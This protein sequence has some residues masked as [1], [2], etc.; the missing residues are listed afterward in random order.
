MGSKLAVVAIGGNSL[1]ADPNQPDIAQQ[2]IAVRQ[3]CNQVALMVAEGWR[4]VLTHGNG[5]QVGYALLRSELAEAQGGYPVPLDIVVAETQGSIGYMLQQAMTNALRRLGHK[6]TVVTVITEVI[7]ARDDPAFNTPSKPIGRFMSEAQASQREASGWQ[8]MED[9]G[10]GWRRVVASPEPLEIVEL[11]AIRTLVDQGYVV[12][13]AGG[14]GVPVYRTEKGSLR[15][16]AAVIDKDRATG[17][18]AHALGADLFLI[19]TGVEQVAIN[20][21]R[22]DQRNVPQMSQAEAEQYLKDGHFAK[23]SMAP[24]IQAVIEFVR[25]G[26]PRA[27]IT[28]PTHLIQAVHGEAGTTITPD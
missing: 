4:V 25:G 5:P 23:G 18:L 11:R 1:I 22:P 12:I 3:I 6:R 15:G 24:K 17:L 14:G 28:D 7:V 26:G 10:R 27:I 21:G 19:S 2:W 9:A 13:T 16:A 8:V 20:F